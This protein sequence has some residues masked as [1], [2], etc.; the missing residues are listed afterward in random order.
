MVV[1]VFYGLQVVGIMITPVNAFLLGSYPEESGEVVAFIVFGRV[2]GGSMAP[3]INIS[4]VQSAGAVTVYGIEA[5]VTVGAS[6]IIMF[7]QVS[8]RRLRSALGPM[9]F[10]Y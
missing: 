1:A 7:L 9:V 2:L 3:Y 5:G 6:L 8:G 10:S 4:R